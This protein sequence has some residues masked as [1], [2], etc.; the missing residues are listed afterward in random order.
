MV[1][2]NR[3]FSPLARL[4]KQRLTSAPVAMVYRVNAGRVRA[5]SWIQDMDVGGGRIVGEVCHFIDLMTFLADS[6]PRRVFASAMPDA[7]GHN[8]TVAINL[9]FDNGSVGSVNYY[10]NGAKG[11][12]KEYLEVHQSGTTALLSD[13]RYLEIHGTGRTQRKK[14][15]MP[16]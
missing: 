15:R 14:L 8:D 7:N 12:A 3:R 10:A 5:E 16:W 11:V 2:F 6:L 13:F 9:E 4:L 1:G